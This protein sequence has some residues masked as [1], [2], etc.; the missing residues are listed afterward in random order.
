MSIDFLRHPSFNNLPLQTSLSLHPFLPF[1]P[2]LTT[3]PNRVTETRPFSG[4]HL[5]PPNTPLPPPPIFLRSLKTRRPACPMQFNYCNA[6]PLDD[7][8]CLVAMKTCS[9]SS[10]SSSS[11]L[12]SYPPFFARA[13][14]NAVE[15]ADRPIRDR[16][17]P[18]SFSPRTN[19]PPSLSLSYIYAH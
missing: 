19:Y 18:F 6:T 17:Y 13:F 5:V 10:S 11:F 16:P 12:L 15:N 14:S 3:R 4:S 2:L 1:S 8:E 7:T 9:F